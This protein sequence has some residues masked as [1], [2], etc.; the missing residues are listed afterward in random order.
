MI[1]FNASNL[2]R[3]EGFFKSLLDTVKKQGKR[4]MVSNTLK[5]WKQ[6]LTNKEPYLLATLW[7]REVVWVLQALSFAVE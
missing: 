7:C 5:L 2:T 3:G 4:G 6:S 1:L